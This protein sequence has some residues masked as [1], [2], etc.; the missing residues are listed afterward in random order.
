M[1]YVHYSLQNKLDSQEQKEDK[2]RCQT[3]TF[4]KTTTPTDQTQKVSQN[5]A[6]VSKGLETPQKQYDTSRN[7]YG[8][9]VS[10]D[11]RPDRKE[12]KPV[13]NNSVP[14]TIFDVSERNDKEPKSTIS[15]QLNPLGE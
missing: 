9:I 7:E 3:Q 2:S 6:I 1:H 11:I 10:G 15:T 8:N 12:F 4:G 5:T 13:I 14:L